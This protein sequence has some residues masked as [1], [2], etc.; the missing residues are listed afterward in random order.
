M[1]TLPT[2]RL[3]LNDAARR[4]A[5]AG[6]DAPLLSAR[7]LAGYALRLNTTQ[8]ICR[9]EQPLSATEREHLDTLMARRAAGEPVAYITGTREFFGR[10]FAV[11]PATLIPRP[12]T[13]HLVETALERL[14]K[15]G[16]RFADGGTGSGCIAVT[17]CA[18]RPHWRG[19]MLDISAE[20]LTVAAGNARRHSADTRLAAVRGDFAALPLRPGSLDL[21]VSNPPYVT[22][23]AYATLSHEVREFEPRAA[24]TPDPSGLAHLRLLIRAASGLLRR[25]GLLLLE[26]GCD[27]GETVLNLLHIGHRWEGVRLGR[28][29]AGL[30][31]YCLA[32]K[33]VK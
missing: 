2:L 16:V 33:P 1:P 31:R 14:P 8:L 20:A 24:L 21:L 17:L 12:E 9:S 22:G 28:D 11:T 7:I 15:Q 23:P 29:L 4:L 25:G 3:Y 6:V 30:D 10:D 13:E 27:Q 32:Y 26:H 19:I 5:G 18:E